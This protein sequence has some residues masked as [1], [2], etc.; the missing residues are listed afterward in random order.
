MD[1]HVGGTRDH[2]D[3]LSRE[4]AALAHGLIRDH[5]HE[6]PAPG[7]THVCGGRRHTLSIRR[8]ASAAVPRGSAA[9]ETK[10]GSERGRV[11]SIRDG[12]DV[13]AGVSLARDAAATWCAFADARPAL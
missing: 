11:D 12:D 9:I 7:L 5:H 6:R 1:N 3:E 10:A 4:A 2:H 13:E 8:D